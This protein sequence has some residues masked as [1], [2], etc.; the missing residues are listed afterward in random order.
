[1]RNFPR[2]T[3]GQ[4]GR[5]MESVADRVT[6]IRELC[7]LMLAKG[8]DLNAPNANGY[9]PLHYAMTLGTMPDEFFLSL[10]GKG[11]NL[12]LVAK[13]GCTPLDVCSPERAIALE[14]LVYF[15]KIQKPNAVSLLVRD[16]EIR[17]R[18]P[19]ETI[20]PAEGATPPTL[21]EMLLK[22]LPVNSPPNSP[23]P[24]MYADFQILIYR[25]DASG[26][27]RQVHK[28]AINATASRPAEAWPD[29]HWGDILVRTREDGGQGGTTINQ[30][31]LKKWLDRDAS[32]EAPNSPGQ[33]P[34]P[35][36]VPRRVI[37]DVK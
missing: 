23:T 15:P 19:L 31:A 22:I 35:T 17:S 37:R 26:T 9:T 34:P 11:A 32:T 29:L 6:K 33:I 36:N 7:D 30:D 21:D 25:L 18:Q 13:D 4:S 28:V 2:S 1:M 10:I 5:E 3:M 16:S 24:W 27:F 20:A 8:A 12:L 14:P